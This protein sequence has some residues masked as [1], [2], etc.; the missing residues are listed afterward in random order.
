[1][2]PS[3]TNNPSDCRPSPL[4]TSYSRTRHRGSYGST[5]RRVSTISRIHGFRDGVQGVQRG[6]VLIR[7]DG[8]GS[9]SYRCRRRRRTSEVG[10]TTP[11]TGATVGT[12]LPPVFLRMGTP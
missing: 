3:R 10:P 6:R 2:G 11:S 5:V 12:D 7:G 9:P 4:G 1:M 8:T